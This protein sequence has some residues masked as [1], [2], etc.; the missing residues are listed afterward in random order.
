MR[1][2]VAFVFVVLSVGVGCSTTYSASTSNSFG[3]LDGRHYAPRVA[4]DALNVRWSQQLVA[5]HNTKFAAVEYAGAALDPDRNRLYVGI[6][7]GDLTAFTLAGARAFVYDTRAGIEGGPAV[8]IG[9]GDVYVGAND[10]VLHALD[11]AGTLRWKQDV[12]EPIVAAPKITAEAVYVVGASDSVIALAKTDGRILWTFRGEPIEEFTIA[13]HSGIALNRNTLV[14]GLTDGR[15][16]AL[17][18]TSG[19]VDW[20]IDTSVDVETTLSDAPDFFDVD[21]TPLIVGDLVFVASFTAG[22]YALER[23]SGTVLW[24]DESISRITGLTA[25]PEGDALYIA[26]AADGVLKLDIESR[27]VLWKRSNERGAPTQPLLT[28]T[29]TLLFGETQGSLFAVSSKDGYELARI[30]SGNGFTATPAA[31]GGIG[32]VI[33]NGG[34]F[35]CFDVR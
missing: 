30:E 27:K 19:N 18:A 22:L 17:D 1:L 29:G 5:R 15:V 16:I 13:G 8:D 35:I 21:T 24:R 6:T 11:E 10:G 2:I 14:T 4:T 28:E 3:W 32:A 7:R 12:S 25:S 31:L 33:T 34:N 9:N 26:S 20:E 23:D